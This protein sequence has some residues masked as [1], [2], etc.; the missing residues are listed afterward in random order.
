V[1]RRNLIGLVGAAAV[2]TAGRIV[3]AESAAQPVAHDHHDHGGASGAYDALVATTTECIN[4]GEACL[5]HCLALL[6]QG[7]RD[8]V[9]CART[10]QSTIAACTALRQLAA[11]NSPRVKEF[12]RLVA[13]VCEDCKAECHKQSAHAP[14]KKCEEACEACAK[15]C[16][17]IA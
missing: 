12:A 10:V 3:A 8:L 2:A 13:L 15:A 9:Q 14:C 5:D 7:E 1:N 6:G 4:T 16:R 17:A 11:V